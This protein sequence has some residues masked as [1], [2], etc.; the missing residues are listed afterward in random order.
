MG[1]RRYTPPGDPPEGLPDFTRQALHSWKL[2]IERS[3]LS[4]EPL[5]IE[6][7]IPPD[8]RALIE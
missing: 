8:L 4:G 3:P 5:R 1:E 7:E 6:E 2:E